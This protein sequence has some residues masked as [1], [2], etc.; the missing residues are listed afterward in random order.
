LSQEAGKVVKGGVAMVEIVLD[1]LMILDGG[2]A[3]EEMRGA[4]AKK[5]AEKAPAGA[6]AAAGA[7]RSSTSHTSFRSRRRWPDRADI[8]PR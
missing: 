3:V 6:A 4:A 1:I 2:I 7:P 5:I 8:R